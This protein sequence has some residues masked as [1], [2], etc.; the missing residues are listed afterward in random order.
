MYSVKPVLIFISGIAA[1]V[2]ITAMIFGPKA[3]A[4][5]K[6][7]KAAPV[8]PFRDVPIS[9]TDAAA[10][11]TMKKT[12]I[13]AGYPNNTYDGSRPVTRY[14]LAVVLARFAQYY[15]TSKAPLASN[16]PVL[17]PAPPWAQPSRQFLASSGFVPTASPLF[18]SPGNSPVSAD[19]LSD[20]LSSTLDRLI[21]LSMP[22]SHPSE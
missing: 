11:S 18:A 15:E 12:G 4:Q 16:P 22:L 10:L 20:T 19:L 6:P 1:G 7:H 21:D 17:L 13:I 8:T 3:S 9:Q 2:I 14:E 5:T